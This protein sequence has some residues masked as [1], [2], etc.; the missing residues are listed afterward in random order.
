M[1]KSLAFRLSTVMVAVSIPAIVVCSQE[2]ITTQLDN[3]KPEKTIYDETV[4]D[5]VYGITMYE[6]LNLQLGG[7]SV[8]HC[9][10][11]ACQSWVEDHYTNGQLLHKGYYIDGQLKI[12]KNYYPDGQ[13]EREFKNIDN[14]KSKATLYYPDGSVKSEIE[15]F[16]GQAKEWTDYWPNGNVEYYEHY[17]KSFEYHLERTSYFEDGSIESQFLLDNKKKLI[18]TK[19]EYHPNGT[20]AVD[21]EMHY[22]EGSWLMYKTGK[23]NYYDENGNS[24]KT[25]TYDKGQLVSK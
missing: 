24:T 3:Q 23:W 14:V 11:Y 13:L 9:D 8:R 22:D 25:E 18:F 4:V 5:S 20:V 16:D 15:Y 2:D 12:Y 17:H 10:G 6:G 1:G 19:V 7:D 21:G